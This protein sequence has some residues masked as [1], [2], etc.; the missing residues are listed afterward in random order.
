MPRNPGLGRC[1]LYGPERK[2][3]P[4]ECCAISKRRLIGKSIKAFV[5]TSY[6][7]KHNQTMRQH[8][9]RFAV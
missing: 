6:V 7:E 1:G 8:M 2:Y 3:S 5:S 9:K 4:G